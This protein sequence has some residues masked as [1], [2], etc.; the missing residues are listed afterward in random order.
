MIYILY[1]NEDERLYNTTWLEFLDNWDIKIAWVECG[2]Y[3][4]NAFHCDK[5]WSYTI[6]KKDKT[7]LLKILNK[8]YNKKLDK[9][10]K[11]IKFTN[12]EK[13][14]K[15]SKNTDNLTDDDKIIFMSLKEIFSV[16]LAYRRIDEFLKKNKVPTCAFSWYW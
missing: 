4:E 5:S 3:R 15:S 11:D 6:K 8:K 13:Y 7:M 12:L 16:E 10:K 9:I 2:S 14:I 1:K